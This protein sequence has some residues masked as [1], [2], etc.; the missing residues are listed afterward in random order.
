MGISFDGSLVLPANGEFQDP[1]NALNLFNKTLGI[2]LIGG[3]YSEAVH[4][5][6]ISY[7]SLFINGYLKIS[8][9]RNG[10]CATFHRNLRHLGAGPLDSIKLIDP[11]TVQVS[12]IVKFQKRGVDYFGNISFLSPIVLL[13]GTT[14]YVKHQFTESLLFLW[15]SIEQIVNHVWEKEIIE[16][17]YDKTIS[18][19]T[20]FLKDYRTWTTSN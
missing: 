10:A 18:G 7:G 2:L 5:E 19:R 14:N 4:P 16:K 20:K 3:L 13:Q 11:L 9:G 17:T 15:T 8:G 1:T 6:D 12:E